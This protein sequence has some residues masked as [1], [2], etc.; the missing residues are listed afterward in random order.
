MKELM[1]EFQQ[2]QLK[3]Y[4]GQ[5]LTDWEEIGFQI[6]ERDLLLQILERLD[7]KE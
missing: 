6:I 1:Q 3:K 7:E 4:L 5:A 2:L